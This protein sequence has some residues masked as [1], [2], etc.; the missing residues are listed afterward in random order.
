M[1]C[2][3]CG[4]QL[5]PNSKYCSKCGASQ[6]A[7][8]DAHGESSATQNN[9]DSLIGLLGASM[10]VI[11]LVGVSFKY[12][13]FNSPKVT[14]CNDHK[15]LEE[16]SITSISA[17]KKIVIDSVKNRNANTFGMGRGQKDDWIVGLLLQQKFPLPKENQL[18]VSVLSYGNVKMQSFQKEILKRQCSATIEYKLEPFNDNAAAYSQFLQVFG[19]SISEIPKSIQV[20]YSIQYDKELKISIVDNIHVLR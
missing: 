19:G 10:F 9:Q 8:V 14:E 20:S 18:N 12:D 3:K 17:Y 15:V 2:T 6:R 16:V 5:K 4:C 13:F 11:A 1:F 7:H